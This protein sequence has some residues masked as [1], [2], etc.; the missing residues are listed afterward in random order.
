MNRDIRLIALALF[1]WGLGEGLFMYI[2]PLYIAELGADPAQIGG[3]LSLM[4]LAAGLTYIP[5]GLLADRLPRKPLLAGGWFSG[6]LAVL[7]SALA[8][9]WRALIP[10]LVLYGLSA[11]CIPV[12]NA[13]V[14]TAAGGRDLERVFT[15]TFAA[16]TAGAV[17][18][19]AVG[20]GLA[21]LL[22]MRAVYLISAGIF[23]F[24]TVVVLQISPQQP[25]KVRQR[26][27]KGR[28]LLT[29]RFIRFAAPV[30]LSFFSMYL[31]FPLAPNFLSDVRGLSTA[32]VGMLGSVYAVGTTL[33]SPILGRLRKGER[34]WGM[35]VG[36]GMV[37]ASAGLLLWA[38]GWAGVTAAFL[39][40]GGYYACRAL[41]QARASDLLG[42]ENR[43][44][45]MGGVQTAMVAAEVLA[46]AVAGWLYE[47]QPTWPF[48]T[49]LALIPVSILLGPLVRGRGD[50]GTR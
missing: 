40:R 6:F 23:A 38:P 21:E 9:D 44:L 26:R 37:W 18:S 47:G 32:Q 22:S 5:A 39:L 34:S 8:R 28:L 17:V 48:L 41:T 12:I 25:L 43:G 27:E 11:Y 10:G 50:T 35:A 33:F 15:T 45:A 30:L 29:R 13:Y 4:G 2:Q 36:Q 49:A 46:P 1:L 3:V 42:E 14:A 7:I 20:G 16:F 31:V 19:P 24:S